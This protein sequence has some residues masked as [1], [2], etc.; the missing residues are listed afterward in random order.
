MSNKNKNKN[1]NLLSILTAS[2]LISFLVLSSWASSSFADVKT[3]F[4]PSVSITEKYTDNYNRTESNRDDEFSTIYSA[5]LSFGV[6]G[7]KANLFLNYNP[8]YTDY[9]D[10]DE[11]DSWSHVASLEGQ[12]NISEHTTLTLSETFVRDM[13]QTLRTNSWE[14]HNTS[15]TMAGVTHKFGKRDSVG[16]NYIYALDKYDDSNADEFVSHNPSAFLSYWFTPQYGVDFNTSYKSIKYDIFNNDQNTWAGDIKFIKKINR[17]FDVYIAYAH[18]YTDQDFGDH[19]TYNPSIGFN[20]QPTEDSGVSIGAGVLFQE[21]DNNSSEDSEDFFANIDIYK[22]FNFSR[23]GVFSVTGSSGYD[24]ADDDAASLGFHIYYEAGCLLSYKMTKKLTGEL[25]GTYKIDQFD[26][27]VVDRND[28]TLG[29]GA[30]LIWSPLQWLSLS[31]SYSFNDYNTDVNTREDY[32]ENIGMVT[33]TM[34]PSKEVRFGTANPRIDL[35][36]RLFN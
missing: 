35:E 18:T 23:R 21:W 14:E 19:T 25:N 31:L 15:T 36:N 26:N 4:V 11:N 8:S 16:F 30:K 5:G 20:W 9:D 29:L 10:Y 12:Y 13:T 7:K 22:N 17:H 24:P 2:L 1:K 27:P 3:Q 34:K 28:N 32:Q 6:I 33:I